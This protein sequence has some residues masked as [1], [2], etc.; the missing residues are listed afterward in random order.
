MSVA[1]VVGTSLQVANLSEEEELSYATSPTG[2][3]KLSKTPA[4]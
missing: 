4:S 1:V 3:Q 2:S